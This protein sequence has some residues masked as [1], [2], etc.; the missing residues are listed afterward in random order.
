MT[1]T[2]KKKPTN[3]F[4]PVRL[5]LTGFGMGSADVVPGVSGGTIAFV[6]GI[7]EELI[8]SIKHVSGTVVKLAI[9]GKIKEAVKEIPWTFLVPLAVGL[10]LAL[11]TM[12]KLISFALQEFP[13]PVWSFFFGLVIASVFM[14]GQKVTKWNAGVLSAFV[15]GAIATYYIVGAVPFETPNT[16][17]AMFIAGAIAIC[18]MIL[19]GISGSFLL[20][21]M[22]KYGQV[23]EAV[24][25]L[26]LVRLGIFM[27][28]CVIG[29]SLFSRLLSW[30]FEKHHN[31]VIAAMTGVMLG[32]LRKLW[33]WKNVLT[34]TVDSHGET[35]PLVV[36][37]VLPRSLDTTVVF[38]LISMVVGIALIAYLSQIDKQTE[39]ST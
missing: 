10:F 2:Q 20:L 16:H 15:V 11:I 31:I 17:I 7:Y 34:T 22:G 38:A 27:V 35:I 36:E 26:D 25:N 37:N 19:P 4:N 9:K 33:P 21:L 8:N 1:K 23:L 14:V 6:F 18:A 32:S 24:N 30:L 13:V 5:F 28:G 12:A 39:K 29:L 3:T